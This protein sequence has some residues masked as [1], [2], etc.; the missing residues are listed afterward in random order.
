MMVEVAILFGSTWSSSEETSSMGT[1][2]RPHLGNLARL[3]FGL[4]VLLPLGERWGWFDTWPG[5]AL[6]ASHAE[7]TEVFLHDEQWD[8]LAPDLRAYL[9]APG[10]DAWRRF[11]LTAWSRAVRGVPVYPQGRACN[12]LAESIAARYGG[13]LLIKVV[14]WGRADLWTGRR[15]RVECL[16]LEAIR[17]HGDGYRLNSHP[18]GSIARRPVRLGVEP[19]RPPAT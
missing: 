7:R 3:L 10:P 2:T 6:Y 14:Q 18:A 9:R 16:G 13:R 4:A 12:G 1:E 19:N 11:D 15:S 5:H 8:E 17:R